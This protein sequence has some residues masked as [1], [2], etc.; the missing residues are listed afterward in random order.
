MNRV[1]YC[2]LIISAMLSGAEAAPTTPDVDYIAALYASAKHERRPFPDIIR[3]NPTLDDA[4]LYAVQK[5][6]N[7]LTARG[8]VAVAGFKGG[9]IPRAPIGGV[10]F[11]DG[12]LTGKAVVARATFQHLLVEAEI[13]FRFCDRIEAP[14]PDIATLQAATCEV[15]PAVEL[16][17]AAL[18][19]LDTLRADLEHLRRILIPTNMAAS[20]LLLGEPR[21]PESIV[22]INRIAVTVS[23]NGK[24]IGTR[25]EE[26]LG[27]DIWSRVLWL[28]N[29][30]VIAEG[31]VVEPHHILIPGAL[32]GLH[33]GKPGDYIIDYGPLG[34]VEFT[35]H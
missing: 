21:K 20:H 6:F 28:I 33:D 19:D 4:T 34:G 17:D 2:V 18:E 15:L 1:L 9:F 16:P 12:I 31:Y 24:P 32:T 11:A 5:R 25:Q 7:A 27:A 22:D 13:G 8:G 23:H 30:Y 29:D 3:I 35:I 10:L 26:P 14:V